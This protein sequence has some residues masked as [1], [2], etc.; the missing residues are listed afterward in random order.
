MI[1]L[2]EIG[3]ARHVRVTQ[4]QRDEPATRHA[5]AVYWSRPHALVARLGSC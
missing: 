4:Y 3:G 1:E 2:F 5:C